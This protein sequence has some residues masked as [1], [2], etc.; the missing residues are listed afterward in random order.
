MRML[1]LLSMAD[2]Q[3]AAQ[4][5]AH[6]SCADGGQPGAPSGWCVT[7][8]SPLN[9]ERGMLW[10][11]YQNHLASCHICQHFFYENIVNKN[12]YIC[13]DQIAQRTLANI[14]NVQ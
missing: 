13:M 6:H 5:E 8:P 11:L 7:R 4:A 1:Q 10:S 14:K 2:L 3:D 12:I 9:R